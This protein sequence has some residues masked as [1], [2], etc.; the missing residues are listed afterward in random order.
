MPEHINSPR[1]VRFFV[2]ADGEPRRLHDALDQ[3]TKAALTAHH[4]LTATPVADQPEQLQRDLQEAAQELKLV[5][6][7]SEQNRRALHALMSSG[8]VTFSVATEG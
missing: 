7:L 3:I 8:P 4:R 2:L 6:G 1:S 5:V